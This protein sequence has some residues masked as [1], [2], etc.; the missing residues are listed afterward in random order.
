[1]LK[2]LKF[3]FI[4]FIFFLALDASIGKYLYKKYIRV[5]LQDINTNVWIKDEFYDHTFIKNYNELAGWG[6]IRFKL[7]TDNNSFKISC[8]EKNKNNK[9]FNIG[10]IGDSFTEAVGM[11]YEESFVGII[12]KELRNKKIAN[13]GV[14]SYGTSIYYTKIKRLIDTGYKFDEIIVFLDISDLIDDTLCYKIENDK[15]IRRDTFSTCWNNFNIKENAF[16]NFYKKNFNFTQILT[17]KIFTILV[18]LNVN[19]HLI[20][21]NV[22]NTSRSE[23]TFK[24]KEEHFNNKKFEDVRDHSLSIMTEL[25]KLLDKN[26]IDL[27]IAV[28]PHP[29]TLY[30]DVRN[31]RQK[32]IWENFCLKNCKNFY[33]FMNIFFDRF[34]GNYYQAYKKYYIND[35]LHFSFEG[36]KLIS[37]EFLLKYF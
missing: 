26:S 6:N 27:S 7:C 15:I 24:Y 29:A 35:D 30:Y 2:V 12:S 31:N 18:S 4:Y 37:S 32:E 28:Y 5:N 36:N 13:L 16:L 22:L 10:F 19:K 3:T 9:I 14:S 8:D 21:S 11:N 17:E 33:N 25:K 1:M 23:W 34:E 20:D